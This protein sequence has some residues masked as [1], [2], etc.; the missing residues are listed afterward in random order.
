MEITLKWHKA[1]EELPK[2]SGTYLVIKGFT[3][4][5]V[6]IQ[7]VSYSSRHRAFNATDNAEPTNAFPVDYWAEIGPLNKLF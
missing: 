2:S 7:N 1:S 4:K 5:C 6:C 3:N